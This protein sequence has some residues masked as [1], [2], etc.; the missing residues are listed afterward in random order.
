MSVSDVARRWLLLLPA[1]S[2][3]P[4]LPPLPL[5]LPVCLQTLHSIRTRLARPRRGR[6]F[7]SLDR[8]RRFGRLVGQRG[9]GSDRLEAVR[10]SSLLQS[11]HSFESA[12]TCESQEACLYVVK[13]HVWLTWSP[14]V[15]CTA[16]LVTWTL[17]HSRRL[18]AS[19]PSLVPATLPYL[20]TLIHTHTSLPTYSESLC[21]LDAPK[22]PIAGGGA[23]TPRA[24]PMHA[25]IAYARSRA[26]RGAL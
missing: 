1:C 2:S 3:T 10:L 12:L 17:R 15:L 20:G 13:K 18:S 14:I 25:R 5:L 26:A 24:G 19:F 7:S 4:V 11:L 23:V 16:S 9:R 8:V 22:V 21:P 6:N